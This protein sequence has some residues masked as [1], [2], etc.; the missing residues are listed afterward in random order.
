MSHAS[1]TAEQ[2]DLHFED[3]GRMLVV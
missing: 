3:R 1:S 2:S